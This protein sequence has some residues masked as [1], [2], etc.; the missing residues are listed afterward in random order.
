MYIVRVYYGHDIDEPEM[1]TV[2][3]TLGPYKTRYAANRAAQSKFDAIKERL[4]DPE[5]RYLE[6]VASYCDYY[7]I[8]GFIDLETGYVD[9]AH[10]YRVSVVELA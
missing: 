8:Y 6:I 5:T 7:V 9:S 2:E 1:A 3:D 4:D 10:Y